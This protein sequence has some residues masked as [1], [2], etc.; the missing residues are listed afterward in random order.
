MFKIINIENFG[1]LTVDSTLIT[2][3]NDIITVDTTTGADGYLFSVPYRFFSSNVKFLIY[4]EFNDIET[5][6]EVEA[7]DVN[8]YMEF[9]FNFDFEDDKTYE[10]KITDIDGKLIWRGKIYSTTQTDLQNY[11]INKNDREV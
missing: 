10:S 9:N 2:V 11:S 7:E 1:N 3:D 5:I 6:I 8:N 4:D